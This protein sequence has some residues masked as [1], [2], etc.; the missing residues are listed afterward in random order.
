MNLKDLVR[1]CI[2]YPLDDLLRGM[3]IRDGELPPM[4]LVRVS[5][6]STFRQAGQ[7]WVSKLRE[8]GG[9]QSGEKV[10]DIGCGSGRVALALMDYLSEEGHYTGVDIRPDEIDW[11]QSNYSTK[12]PNFSFEFINVE[13]S[14]YSV[15]SDQ[16]QASKFEFPFASNFY[17]MIFLT[18]VFTHMLPASV[19]HY[20]K[21]IVRML[22]PGGR[23]LISYFL[24]NESAR[25]GIQSG[26]SS[27]S[28]LQDL[29]G[30]CFTDNLKCP[31]DAVAFEESWIRS[32]YEN[33]RLEIRDPVFQGQWSRKR[34]L[35]STRDYQDI[36]VAIK[37]V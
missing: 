8:I 12:R 31:E 5:P 18:S 15:L 23:C 28:F 14:F 3:G 9:L 22:K 33:H 29:G 19:D 25:K 37:P 34:E 21:E 27:R 10:L 11:L 35:N 24:M 13:N 4:R 26:T 2:K 16:K 20:L 6:Y 1:K 32:L 7:E 17:D 30:G 36:I